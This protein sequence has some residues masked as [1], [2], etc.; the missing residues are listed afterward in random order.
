MKKK[1]LLIIVCFALGTALAPKADA[2]LN[3]FLGNLNVRARAD[4]PGFNARMSA[5]F[6]IP[7]PHVQGVID[8]MPTPADAFMCF[9]IGRMTGESPRAVAEIFNHNRHKGWGALAK[10]LGIKPG[11]AEFHA[12][13]RGDFAL[14]GRPHGNT[15]RGHGKSQQSS[16][17]K[18]KSPGKGKKKK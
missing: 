12:L 10:E 3:G 9:Q 15:A 17:A 16:G 13:K 7:V 5:Q 18:G 14:T 8:I 11:S 2:D 4:L 1:I 6:G